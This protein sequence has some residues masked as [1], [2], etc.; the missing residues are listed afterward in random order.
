QTEKL[1]ELVG[2]EK[3]AVCGDSGDEYG[4]DLDDSPRKEEFSLKL[5]LVPSKDSPTEMSGTIVYATTAVI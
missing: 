3:V 5:L 1:V 4:I 2:G